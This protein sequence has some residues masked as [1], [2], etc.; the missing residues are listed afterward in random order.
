MY[1]NVLEKIKFNS[2][3]SRNMSCKVADKKATM[4]SRSNHRNKEASLLNCGNKH[5]A[6][7][8]Q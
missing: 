1:M 6:L 8:T 5:S 2:K 4:L 3:F 7:W